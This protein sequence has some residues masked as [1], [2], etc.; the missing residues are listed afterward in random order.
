MSHPRTSFPTHVSFGA[1]DR[2]FRPHSQVRDTGAT[3][4]EAGRAGSAQIRFPETMRHFGGRCRGVIIRSMSPAA[5]GNERFY[6]TDSSSSPAGFTVRVESR[7]NPRRCGTHSPITRATVT[8][9]PLGEQAAVSE[10]AN[11]VCQRIKRRPG[12]VKSPRP[13]RLAKANKKRR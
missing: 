8:N 4:G 5:A 6:P 9:F 11:P 3:G 10:S 7:T 12:E 13:L 2:S 1:R